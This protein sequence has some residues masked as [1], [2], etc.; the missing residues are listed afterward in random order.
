MK[1]KLK[2]ETK[3]KYSKGEQAAFKALSATPRSSTIIM[4]KVYPDE[5]PN[6]GR[7]IV[8]IMLGSL[9]KKMLLNK[10]PFKLVSS[11]RS[12]PHAMLFH[13]EVNKK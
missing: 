13:L 10:E 6:N 7:K 12:G 4:E 2:I 9:R 3:V 1:F 5:V 11:P 8:I